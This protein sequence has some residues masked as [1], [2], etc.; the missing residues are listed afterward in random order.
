MFKKL[1]LLLVLAAA[2]WSGYWFWGAQTL[3][4]EYQTWFDARE[5]EGWQ[6][7]YS[8]LDV[9]GFP[10]RFDTTWSDLALA[11]PET[12]L[13]WEAPFFQLLMLS[14]KPN[15][16]I[17]IWP[18]TH[19]FSSVNQSFDITNDSLQASLVTDAAPDLPLRRANLAAETL[20]LTETRSGD[21]TALAALRAAVERQEDTPSY[22]IAATADG[23]ALSA[24]LLRQLG[25]ALPETFSTARLDMTATFDT[26]WGLSAVETARPQPTAIDLDIAE[27]AWGPMQLRLSGE[28]EIDQTG[29]PEGAVSLQARE[30]R[31]MLE[32]AE[33]TELLPRGAAEAIAGP[34][35][36]LAALSG[37][38]DA[39]DVELTFRRGQ[40][41]LGPLPLGPAPRIQLR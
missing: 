14:Y 9:R 23:L 21:V 19:R 7:E 12:G 17:A 18:D 31:D 16:V 38:A 39:L 36:A 29:R 34:L 26:P 3:K 41:F 10:N 32:L 24:P 11:D 1:T 5:S 13:A 4:S 22:R 27:A 8:A 6:A 2:L 40:V 25:R 20:T 35:G 37:N 33:A 15:H 28:L 30:W